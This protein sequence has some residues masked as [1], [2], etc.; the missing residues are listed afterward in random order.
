MSDYVKDLRKKT[1]H[2][3]LLIAHSAVVILND[4]N[5]VLLEERSDDG[6]FDFPGGA[7]DLKESL[8]DAAKRELFEETGISA[9]ELELLKVYSGDITHYTYFNGDE[10]YGVDAVYVCKKYEGEL[11]PQLDEVKHLF[12]CPLSN[13][14]SKMSIRNKQI[15]KDLKEK[16]DL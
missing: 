2:M 14:P 15:I 11:K 10:I 9:L 3:T 5:E 16:Y 13:M 4:K 6:Y 1:G 12:Y 8:E 7:L